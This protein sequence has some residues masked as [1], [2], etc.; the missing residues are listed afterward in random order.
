MQV[1]GAWHIPSVRLR[2]NGYV[3]NVSQVWGAIKSKNEDERLEGARALQRF[4]QLV[5][6]ICTHT[7]VGITV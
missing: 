3:M 2:A 1:S 6:D 4:V 5:S 7:M